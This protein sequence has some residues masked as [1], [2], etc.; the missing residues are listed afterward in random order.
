MTK[1]KKQ[2]RKVTFHIVG[3]NEVGENYDLRFTIKASYKIPYLVSNE[4]KRKK[5][6]YTTV[7][8]VQTD[9]S[10]IEKDC[11]VFSHTNTE[12]TRVTSRRP[13]YFV[14]ENMH[15][16]QLEPR[17]DYLYYLKKLAKII[18]ESKGRSEVNLPSVYASGNT[19]SSAFRPKAINNPS[20]E[21]TYANKTLE[22][23]LSEI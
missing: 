10:E 1:Q 19:P 17:D 23:R 11:F 15:Q 21:V 13:A 9:S 5:I 12:E 6:G 8:E 18:L 7:Q 2:N 3:L 14:R 20:Y 4:G 22:K 16:M